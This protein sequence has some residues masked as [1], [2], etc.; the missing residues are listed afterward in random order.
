MSDKRRTRRWSMDQKVNCYLDGVRLDANSL[1]LSSA[2]MFL[3]TERE[4]PPGDR[5]AVVFQAP[6]MP[7][8]YFMGKVV[9]IQISPVQGLG[10]EFE[11]AVSTAGPL[12]LAA[13]LKDL[14][15]IRPKT[16][17]RRPLG[18]RKESHCIYYFPQLPPEDPEGDGDE[19]DD[20]ATILEGGL[21]GLDLSDSD[22]QAMPERAERRF[23]DDLE[24][25]PLTKTVE[26]AKAMAPASIPANMEV[27]DQSV[28]VLVDSLGLVT[29]KVKSYLVPYSQSVDIRLRFQVVTRRG[30][31]PVVCLCRLKEVDVGT[32]RE[33]AGLLL[34]IA[35]VNE[36]GQDGLLKRYV[37]WL[38]FNSLSME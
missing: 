5:L 25:G 37:R 9:R 17:S 23:Q 6:D 35:A 24:P 4:F 29:A 30:T 22:V 14:L 21:A 2:G 18:D 15:H 31:Y 10:V 36:S 26:D 7:P 12:E 8:V 27:G 33:D 13:F 32:H 28:V 11:R 3:R 34:E 1:D 38:H 19:V 16:I 20:E